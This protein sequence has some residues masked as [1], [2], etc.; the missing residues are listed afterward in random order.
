MTIIVANI[1]MSLVNTHGYIM[2][3]YAKKEKEM[4]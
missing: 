2:V 1:I 4:N 3:K